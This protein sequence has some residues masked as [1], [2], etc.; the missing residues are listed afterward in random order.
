MKPLWRAWG[1]DIHLLSCYQ[2]EKTS[3]KCSRFLRFA[4]LLCVL[5]NCFNF[6]T[7]NARLKPAF[8]RI[9]A[10]NLLSFCNIRAARGVDL[11]NT[12]NNASEIWS[13][14]LQALNQG[15]QI[16]RGHRYR[17]I[18]FRMWYSIKKRS[19]TLWQHKG[20]KKNPIKRLKEKKLTAPDQTLARK[21]D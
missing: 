19:E 13:V 5:L 17:V 8:Q 7:A 1:S 15:C 14:I 18:T 21:L 6:S 2:E 4:C 11:W 12:L 10:A 9:S 20:N 3:S 16:Y